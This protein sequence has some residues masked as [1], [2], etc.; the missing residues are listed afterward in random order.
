MVSISSYQSDLST[1][2][3]T[4]SFY[5][6]ACHIHLSQQMALQI[7]VSKAWGYKS[8]TLCVC[9]AHMFSLCYTHFL[10]VSLVC[11]LI[12]TGIAKFPTVCVSDCLHP[13]MH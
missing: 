5:H 11:A 13:V 8:H 12:P 7:H 6:H 10:W 1:L 9:G 2:T 4:T 3:S